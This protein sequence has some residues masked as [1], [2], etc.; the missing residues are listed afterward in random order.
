MKNRLNHLLTILMFLWSLTL[1]SQPPGGGR[2]PGG[3][4][5]EMI[6]REKQALYEKVTDLS[7]D[8]KML[9]DG[10]Y[11]EFAVTLKEA[12]EEMRQSNLE[13]EARREKMQ[14]LLKEKN[15]LI[16]D[17]LNEEQYKIYEN[18]IA[19]RRERRNRGN[20]PGRDGQ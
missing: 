11:D 2:R 7:D 17:V 8:Q 4:A 9:L 13:R 18:M 16:A 6:K 15:E 19:T 1:L 20:G 14:S 3:G 10:I 12:F 5:E